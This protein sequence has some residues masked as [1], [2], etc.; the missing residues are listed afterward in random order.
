[1]LLAD[2]AGPDPEQREMLRKQASRAGALAC[3]GDE[4]YIHKPTFL[5]DQIEKQKSRKAARLRKRESSKISS[6][7]YRRIKSLRVLKRLED[8]I[9]S[10]TSNKKSKIESL[11]KQLKAEKDLLKKNALNQ[12]LGREENLL[13]VSELKLKAVRDRM[14]E[15]ESELRKSHGSEEG[16]TPGAESAN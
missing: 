11:R 14:T 3:I 16:A 8:K 2:Q 4:E 6:Y 13:I 1:M 12:D 5:N 7:N 10:G 15:I 9:L